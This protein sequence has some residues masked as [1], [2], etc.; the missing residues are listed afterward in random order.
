[1]VFLIYGIALCLW[2]C[3]RLLFWTVKLMIAF[4]FLLIVAFSG[5]KV[6]FSPWTWYALLRF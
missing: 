4:V 2:L 1:M 5:G 3:A 6:R